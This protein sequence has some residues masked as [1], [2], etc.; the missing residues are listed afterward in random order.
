ARARGSQLPVN[1]GD[2]GIVVGA[3]LAA[4]SSR[5]G[6]FI[7]TGL[8]LAVVLLVQ[9]RED[10]LIP[11]LPGRVWPARLNNRG[12]DGAPFIQGAERS[13]EAVQTIKAQLFCQLRPWGPSYGMSSE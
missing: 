11:L 12:E 5:G 9:I 8:E 7:I 13:A 1:R 3:N 2:H 10:G 4:E 6:D